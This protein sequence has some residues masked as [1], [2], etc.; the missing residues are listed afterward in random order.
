MEYFVVSKNE[1]LA[2]RWRTRLDR[3]GYDVLDS[4]HED[5]IIV[6]IGGDGTILYA[7]RTYLD[8]TIFPVRTADSAGNRTQVDIKHLDSAIETLEA[9]A[10]TLESLPQLSVSVDGSEPRGDFAALNDLNIHHT[11]S[12]E[13]AV[14]RPRVRSSTLDREFPR[15][16]GDGMLVATPF[17]S[18]AYYH[19]VTDGLFTTGLGVGFNN[20]HAPADVPT[21]LVL[22]ADAVVE[23]DVLST[24]TTP[25][26]VLSRDDDP[27]T[28]DLEA[29]TTVE[30]S[31]GDRSVNLVTI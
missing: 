17:G 16:I 2:E 14:F 29:E 31:L 6:T 7:A 22:S 20:I 26:A 24:N 4:Y 8:P 23:V 1:S 27:T 12:T 18:T 5:A 30:I 9:D 19:A 3:G 11:S 10:Y 13:A 28:Y 15:L 21:H 25:D